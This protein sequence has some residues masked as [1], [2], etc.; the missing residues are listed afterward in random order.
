MNVSGTGPLK[1]AGS[2]GS[3]L[4]GLRIFGK[5]VQNGGRA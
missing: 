2:N 4:T 1:L 5:S 3:P